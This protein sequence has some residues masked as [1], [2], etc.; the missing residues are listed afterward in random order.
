M[1][2]SERGRDPAVTAEKSMDEM[3]AIAFLAAMQQHD[4]IGQSA[5]A[6]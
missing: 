4:V 2:Q 6:V 1:R 5:R 3:R